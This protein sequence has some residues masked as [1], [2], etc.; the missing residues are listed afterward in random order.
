MYFRALSQYPKLLPYYV[1]ANNDTF[2]SPFHRNTPDHPWLHWVRHL[3]YKSLSDATQSDYEHVGPLPSQHRLHLVVS[4]P[5]STADHQQPAYEVSCH[6]L[7]SSLRSKI[8]LYKRGTL[9]LIMCIETFNHRIDKHFCVI[10]TT[11]ST[12][13]SLN[14]HPRYR[15]GSPMSIIGK[16]SCHCA[17][18]ES[19]VY[20]SFVATTRRSTWTHTTRETF[21]TT[22]LRNTYRSALLYSMPIFCRSNPL[23]R[24]LHCLSACQSRYVV[25]WRRT[26]NK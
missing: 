19:K 8:K 25:C 22:T 13:S 10:F 23:S 11:P 4:W 9:G 12:S 16:S 24:K 6:F 1:S 21:P 20:I 3:P 17:K 5:R 14:T 15:Y 2:K 18:I 26:M 7:T